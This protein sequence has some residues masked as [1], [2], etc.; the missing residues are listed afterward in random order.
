MSG[1]SRAETSAAD[2]STVAAASSWLALPV[3]MAG[4]FMIVLDFFV[5]YVALP[6]MQASL[7]ASAGALEWVVAG[8]GLIFAVFLVT[9]GRLGDHVGR[10]RMFSTGMAG[11]VVTSAACGAAP[12]TAV[13][14]VARLA[15]GVAAALIS[16]SVLAIIGVTYTGAARAR[17]I[18]VYGVVMGAAAAGGQVVGGLLIAANVAGLSCRTVF[19]INVPVGV[20]ALAVTHRLVP[21]SRAERASGLDLVGMVLATLVLVAVVLPLVQGRQL[22]WPAWAWATLAASPMLFGLFLAH[23][24]VLERRG[25][26]PLLDLELFRVAAFRA[27]LLTQLVFWCTQASTFLVLALYLQ[28]GRGLDALH[29]GLVFTILAGAYVLTSVR[30]PAAAVR[31]GP[32]VVMIGAAAIALGD[33]A[34]LLAVIRM[35]V[36]GPIA[37]LAPGLLLVGAGQGLCVTPL[38]TMVLS[39]ANGQRAGA[40]SG[41]LST[42]QQVGNSVGVAVTGVLFF[43]AL[44]H[45]HGYAVALRW[46]LIELACLQVVVAA[47]TIRLS[48]APTPSSTA[49]AKPGATGR[50]QEPMP[51]EATRS[52]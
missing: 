36:G 25:R 38:T 2:T 26:S 9:A 52:A 6:S 34:L 21:E 29:A 30:A 32:P 47:L 24:R 11:F 13:L 45:G 48:R 33:V 18:S 3:L 40:V 20:A 43:G 50:R 17:A 5:V 41:A 15:Q 39:H 7:H 1:V 4:T 42:M 37:L 19:L 16:A 51:R 23:Q 35:G 49:P 22:G 44:A 14:I 46:S 27:G 10:R 31:F 8:Y 28:S 12:D